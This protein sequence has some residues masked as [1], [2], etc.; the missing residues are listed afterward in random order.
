MRRNS[1]P[2]FFLAA[3]IAFTASGLLHAQTVTMSALNI[4]RDG[5]EYAKV[6]GAGGGGTFVLLSN[7]PIDNERARTGLRMRKNEIAYFDSKLDVKWKQAQVAKPAAGDP[8]QLFVFRDHLI[9]V[10]RIISK[11]ESEIKLYLQAFDT[12]GKE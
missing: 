3:L 11:P 4:D 8:D 1:I 9:S 5:A 10:T 2:L 12:S 7:L 6:L